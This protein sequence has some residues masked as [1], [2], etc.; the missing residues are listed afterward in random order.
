[1]NWLAHILLAGPGAE[2]RLGGVLADMLSRTEA[3]AM[4]A[5]IRRGIALHQ[6]IDAFGDAHPA[7]AV[8]NRRLTSAGVGLRPAAAGIAVDVLYD[9]LLARDWPRYCPAESLEAFAAGF[10]RHAADCTAPIPSKVRR[11]LDLMRAEDWLASYSDPEE[12]RAVLGRIR[13]R[14]SPRAAEVSPLASAV[15]VFARDPGG[16]AEDFAWFWPDMVVHTRAFLESTL[17]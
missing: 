17:G 8:S 4:P 7:A 16:F 2:S 5:G 6:N 11:G 14:L 12:I 3:G 15:D 9:H 1:M 13:R 10:Y